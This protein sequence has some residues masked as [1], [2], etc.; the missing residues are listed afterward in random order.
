M[1]LQHLSIAV[2]L[3][4]IAPLCAAQSGAPFHDVAGVAVNAPSA[5]LPDEVLPAQATDDACVSDVLERLLDGTTR[6][7]PLACQYT[8]KTF[9]QCPPTPPGCIG[10]CANRCCVYACP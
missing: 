6:P 1:R 2:C 4:T 3:L 8:C 10:G 9:S 7:Q 5:G